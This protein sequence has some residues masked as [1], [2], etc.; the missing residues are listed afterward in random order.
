MHRVLYCVYAGVAYVGFLLTFLYAIGFLG[1]FGVPKSVDSG[2]PGPMGTAILINLLLLL[3]FGVHHSVTA[4]IA[5]KRWWTKVIPSEI[6]R[7]TYVLI[8]DL[9]FALILWQWRPIPTIVW[10]FDSTLATFLLWGL[11]AFGW[12][13]VVFS[14]FL[15][16]HFDL[17]GL[18]HVYLYWRGQEYTH[19]P[20]KERSLYRWI[21][22]PLLLGWL[23]AF[24]STPKMTVGHLVFAGGTTVYIVIGLLLE[25]QTLRGILG[26][27]YRKYCERTARFIPFRLKP[28]A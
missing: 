7:S 19:S 17:F 5:F 11:F 4:R 1:N 8:S 21:R 6:E 15:I 28:K 16:D 20:F 12:I 22:H 24:W 3:L 9:L 13:L 2:T 27:E 10:Q 26:E 14:S 23:I 18:R 25:E